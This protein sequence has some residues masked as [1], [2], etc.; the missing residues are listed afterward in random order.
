MGWET[1]QGQLVQQL[2]RE[3]AAGERVLGALAR[4]PRDMFVSEEQRHLAFADTALPIG[5]DQTI[6]QPT[7]VAMMTEALDVGPDHRVL[8]VGTGSGYQTA[9]LAELAKE[10]ISLERNA[11]LA[12]RA[13]RLLAY[14]GYQNVQAV[15]GDGTLGWP[16]ERPYDRIVV[17]AAGP[18]VP[19]ALLDQLGANGR[20]VLPVG[21]RGDQQLLV[22]SRGA[23]GTIRQTSLGTVRFVPLVG[24]QGWPEPET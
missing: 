1:A 5:W 18:T 14:L 12:Q 23:D 22:V 7:V 3:H 13:G 17:T 20:L 11:P 16:A 10:V 4:V 2:R 6:S 15:V 9:V 21:G 8:E 19:L 24:K